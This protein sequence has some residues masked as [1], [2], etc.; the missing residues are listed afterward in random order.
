M[1][2]SNQRYTQLLD[3]YL[4]LK[5]SISEALLRFYKTYPDILVDKV[6]YDYFQNELVFRFQQHLSSSQRVQLN[7]NQNQ[8]NPTYS[9]IS[10][11]I[12]EMD[13]WLKTNQ[14]LWLKKNPCHGPFY[15]YFASIIDSLASIHSQL[16]KLKFLKDLIIAEE[17]ENLKSIRK[18]IDDIDKLRQR[19][20]FDKFI[21]PTHI[22]PNLAKVTLVR[23]DRDQKELHPAKNHGQ[24]TFPTHIPSRIPNPHDVTRKITSKNAAKATRLSLNILA[25][26]CRSFGSKKRSIEQI[27]IENSVDIAIVSELNMKTIPRIK[28]FFQFCNLST[29]G[30]HGTAI[31][32]Q[33]Y[34]QGQIIR[35]PD[36]DEIELVHI[37]VKSTT[38]MLN[39]IGVYLDC[40]GRDNNVDKSC[41]IMLKLKNKVQ[42]IIAKGQSVLLMGDMN[43]KINQENK[44]PST[45][46]LLEWLKEETMNLLNNPC[47]STRIDPVSGKGSTLDLAIVSTD[48]LQ[49]VNSFT[50]DSNKEMTPFSIHKKKG[51]LYKKYTDHF[52]INLKLTL[53]ATKLKKAKNVPYIDLKNKNGWVKYKEISDKYANLVE[54]KVKT[55]K[56]IDQLETELHIIETEILIDSFGIKWRKPGRKIKKRKNIKGKELKEMVDEDIIELDELLS[57]GYKCKDLSQKIYKL[58]EIIAGPKIKA[59]ETMAINDPATGE[60][61]TDPEQIKEVSLQHNLKI[62]KKDEPRDQDKEEIIAK[63]ANHDEV[64][65]KNNKDSWDLSYQLFQNVTSQIKKKGKKMFNPLNKAGEK[66]KW[67]FYSYMKRIIKTEET[68]Y[69]FND[70]KLTQIW[71]GKGSRLDLNNMRFIHGREW[72]SRLLDKIVTEKM[73]PDIVKAC[74]NIQLGGIP[75]SSSKDHLITLKTLMKLKEERKEGLILNTFDMKKF[76]DKE[77]LMDA[78]YTLNKV[79]KVDDKSY[80]LWYKMNENTRISVNTTAGVSRS[81][82]VTDSLGQ[83][84]MGAALVS[85]LNI[86]NAVQNI[87]KEPSTEIG[88]L[89]LNSLVFQDD[90][91]KLSNKLKDAREGCKRID[92]MLKR[93]L[94][95][96]NYDKSK[97][98]ILGNAKFKRKITKETSTNP[99]TMGGEI[100]ERSQKEKY[101]GDYI[102]EDGCEASIAE[103]IKRRTSSLISKCA[104]IVQIGESSIMAGLGNSTTAF[105]LY[106][107]IIIPAL[108]HNAESWI[109][110][111]EANIKELQNFQNNFIRK[112]LRL[113]KSTPKAILEWDTKMM[114]MKYRIMKMK[115]IEMM[116]IMKKDNENITKQAIEQER[117]L[118]IQ[119]LFHECRVASE[120]LE[121]PDLLEMDLSKKQIKHACME[122]SRSE[123]KQKMLDGKKVRD[124][125]NDE[126]EERS[127]LEYMTL[128]DSRI[129]MRIRA[130]SIKGVKINNKGSFKNSLNCRFCTE[131][132]H[133]TQEHL[134]EC[135]G[136]WYER[137]NL[138]LD[139]SD[140][141]AVLHF[142]RRMIAKIAAVTKP[143]T[144]T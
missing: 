15:M 24:I 7:V 34:L 118:G 5:V 21:T 72:R 66:Y 49:N 79:A 1:A 55:V 19:I 135:S 16:I 101:L 12:G 120:E 138:V 87:F 26:N 90:I 131:E 58:K 30:F 121:M 73:K 140:W 65:R 59:Q 43:K 103:T 42:D 67:A 143:G 40:E 39:L 56:C 44:S 18:A 91:S 137:R 129:W 52:S 109:G 37:L 38:P 122:K 23:D 82:N 108:L 17:L 27:L 60:L 64:M 75:G 142:W 69:A 92:D 99:L 61:I 114:S 84:S 88:E 29:R 13:V 32:C 10:N 81:E 86:G 144:L 85:T 89:K 134:Q 41:R 68:P 8:M 48:I 78:M 11:I 139:D 97:Y 25:S 124:R 20:N 111:T 136:T 14:S 76:F 105:K 31:F 116:K 74:P 96:V 113:P 100:I 112:V 33:N 115:L 63:K 47:L 45:N 130:R 6:V 9:I 54:E 50:I 53:P 94:L 51:D 133:E 123:C 28:G 119:G 22:P 107:A 117:K 80:R 125:V 70:T 127:Y 106:E 77:S 128:Q 83:G 36:E 104:E 126:T 98:V 102:H 132:I 4:L 93:K 71:K 95:S 110:I 141:K 35:I 3:E 2:A 46:L 57:K 62:L